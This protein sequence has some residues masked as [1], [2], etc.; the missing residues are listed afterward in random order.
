MGKVEVDFANWIQEAFD[1]YKDH[2][3]VLALAGVIGGLLS[4]ITF[5]VLAGPMLAGLALIVLRLLD[6]SDPKPQPADLFKGFDFF[7]PAFLLVLVVALTGFLVRWI[8]MPLAPVALLFL[9]TCLMF[10]IFLIVD[11]KYEFWPAVLGSFDLVK[12]N[13]WPLLALHLVAVLLGGLGAFGCLVGVLVTWPFTWCVLA[14]AY[15]RC[16]VRGGEPALNPPAPS[17]AS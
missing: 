8:V 6:K 17:A 12:A 14:V 7:L 1:L 16:A 3:A 10:S 5:G 11:R 2:F 9:T 4:G 15:R 13:F